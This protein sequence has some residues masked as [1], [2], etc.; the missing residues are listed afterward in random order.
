MTHKEIS[1][2]TEDQVL[3]AVNHHGETDRKGVIILAP[4][5]FMTKDAYIFS[6]LAKELYEYQDILAL[7]FRG[8]GKSK[9][10][11]TF[12]AKEYL[13]L[14]AVVAYAREIYETITIIGFSLGAA[15]AILYTAIYGGIDKLVLVSPPADF[16]KIENSVWKKDAWL[17]TLRK[18]EL[19]RALSIRPGWPFQPKQKPIDLISQIHETPTLFIAGKKDPTVGYWHTEALFTASHDPKFFYSFDDGLHAEDLYMAYAAEFFEVVCTFISE[20]TS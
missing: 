4:G 6:T 18:F 19:S 3:L 11:F 17:P 12:S 13:D 5:W 10:R 8:H 7:D 15:S 9:G 2:K 14:K 20:T 16:G 1:L